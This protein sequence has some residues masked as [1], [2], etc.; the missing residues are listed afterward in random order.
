MKNVSKERIKSEPREKTNQIRTIRMKH[1]RNE[2]NS[3]R[4]VRI[5]FRELKSQLECSILEGSVMGT[6]SVENDSIIDSV[7]NDSI[8][9]WVESDSIV[10]WVE[11][12]SIFGWIENGSIQHG[13]ED[14]VSMSDTITPQDTHPKMTAFQIMI[15]L[16]VGAPETPDG[17]SSWSLLKSLIN[18][19][20]DGVDI[21]FLW[22]WI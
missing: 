9:G 7:E 15:L 13:R 5:F 17:G 21:V 1:F 6:D 19:L 10:G 14:S 18:L 12:G 4:F 11:N 8:F 20:R 3:W 16:S 2:S 22:V